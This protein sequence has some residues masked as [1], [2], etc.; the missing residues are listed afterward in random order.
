[1]A[2]RFGEQYLLKSVNDSGECGSMRKSLFARLEN[3]G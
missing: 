3:K 2:S 1:V